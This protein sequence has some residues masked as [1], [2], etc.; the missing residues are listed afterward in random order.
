VLV[1]QAL[2]PDERNLVGLAATGAERAVDEA[3]AGLAADQ[4]LRSASD[5]DLVARVSAGGGDPAQLSWL[6]VLCGERHLSAAIDPIAR[7]LAAADADVRAAALTALVAIGDPRAVAALVHDVDF[8]D[9]DRLRTLIEAVTALGGE[10]AVDFLEFVASGHPDA[11]I[12][13]RASEGL[14]RLRRR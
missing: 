5:D 14:E 7:Q 11:D 3:A 10:D 12:K 2:A 13:R 1:E 4:A 9:Y 6:F 8:Q